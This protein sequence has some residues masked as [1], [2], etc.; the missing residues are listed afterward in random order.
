MSENGVSEELIDAFVV[1]IVPT[2]DGSFN[3]VIRLS[4]DKGVMIPCVV[5]GRKGKATLEICDRINCRITY[6]KALTIR[7][8]ALSEEKT[9]CVVVCTTGCYRRIQVISSMAAAV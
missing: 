1:K 6:C 4:D 2:D 9:L 7:E 5:S 3:W 8:I